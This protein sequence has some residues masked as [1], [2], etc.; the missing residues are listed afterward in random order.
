VLKYLES[1]GYI[2]MFIAKITRNVA[3]IEVRHDE[4]YSGSSKYSIRNLIPL[5]YKIIFYYHDGLRNLVAR[6]EHKIPYII[7]R[8]IAD[9]KEVVFP[10][11]DR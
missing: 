6:K 9:G 2:T 11:K 10:A 7:E 1:E 3:E 8:K 5:F 4:R